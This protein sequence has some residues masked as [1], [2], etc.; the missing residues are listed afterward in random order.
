M[1]TKASPAAN[2]QVAATGLNG[3][4][5]RGAKIVAA[6]RV[7]SIDYRSIVDNA[8][9]GLARNTPD[10][11]REVYTQARET[12]KRHLGLMRLP[13][14]IVELEKLSLDLTIRKIERRWQQQAAEAAGA[15]VAEIP[16]KPGDSVIAVAEALAA[17]AAAPRAL[18]KALTALI[19]A[20]CVRRRV[21]P[22][23]T[24]KSTAPS[25]AP[26]TAAWP[27]RA[28]ARRLFSPV[29]LAASL[30]IAAMAIF[31]MFFASN[32]IAHR[33][34]ADGPAGR[35]LAGLH[36]LPAAPA[37]SARNRPAGRIEAATPGP[38]A[39]AGVPGQPGL[40]GLPIA[41][42]PS[43]A[44]TPSSPAPP[45]PTPPAPPPA[46]DAPPRSAA[47]E[48][49]PYLGPT[50]V[51]PIRADFAGMTA[52]AASSTFEAAPPVES[53]ISIRCDNM[54]FPTER[55]TCA[56][57]DWSRTGAGPAEAN[58]AID[59]LPGWLSG[60]AVVHDLSNPRPPAMPAAPT[61][62]STAPST[63]STPAAGETRSFAV[64]SLG[65]PPGSEARAKVP[66]APVPAAPPDNATGA[67]DNATRPPP[68]PPAAA[69]PG[70]ANARVAAF[71][72][73]GK[74]AAV[75]GDLDGAVRNFGEAI[76][77]DPKSPD[78]YSERG[79][80]LFKLGETERAIADYSAAIQRDPQFGA[81]L[82]ARGM[83]YLYR[84][85]TDLALADLSRAIQ[86]AESNPSLLA[87]IELFYARRSRATIYGG[88]QQ[89]DQEIADCTALIASY[90]RDP[91]VSQ[92][93]KE[94]Y[95]DIGAANIV[96]TVYRQRA[97]AYVKRSNFEF[98]IDDLAAAVPLS[99]DGGYSALLD[100]SKLHERIGLRDQAIADLQSALAV[101]PGSEEVRMAL[102]RLG[103]ALR[104]GPP[105]P[106]RPI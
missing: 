22:A 18:A 98:A 84:G 16:A 104:P 97:A 75:K 49:L 25:P 9:A 55:A 45:A 37:L 76:R 2:R 15:A 29:G 7:I 73:S 36:L 82:R 102:K 83:A 57:A 26:S 62:P 89:Y 17:A 38:T 24:A 32:T 77:I 71:I 96:A 80:A 86:L 69:T 93:L 50:K 90:A 5:R 53:P 40:P 8:V 78:S 59:G 4:G 60:Y 42:P 56:A 39:A 94:N 88:K 79:Q 33:R 92:A 46:A 54:P 85:S 81:A 106:A 66:A 13:E 12:V 72:E 74:R 61:A 27:L 31:I 68:P 48:T 101:R 91:I 99:S 11:R 28:V 30:L 105:A 3:T 41:S 19:G 100:R 87:P 95:S 23:A 20:L 35:W 43:T 34:L 10:A 67:P 63:P 70:G 14:P 58:A 52:A 1:G 47:T 51:G 103:G 6:A 65:A 64:A 21:A 44:E